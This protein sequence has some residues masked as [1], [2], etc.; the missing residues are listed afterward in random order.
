MAGGRRK[1]SKKGS[2]PYKRKYSRKGKATTLSVGTANAVKALIKSHMNKVVETKIADY[3]F[4]PVPLSCF[5]H[6]V[7]YSFEL[8]PFTLNQ[9]VQDSEFLNPNNRIGDSVF[10][11][12]IMF[13]LLLTN[14][15]NWPNNHIR[16]LLLKCKAG[17]TAIANPT[18]HPQLGN[19]LILP[20]DKED[21]R[22]RDV[23]Y[24]R[25]FS[26]LSTQGSNIADGIDKTMIWKHYV[27]VNK[28][29]KYDDAG[30]G[31]GND[32]YRLYA[33]MYSTQ[34]TFTTTN[35]GRFSYFRRT[36]FQDA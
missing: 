2:M 17:A 36:Y 8:D 34:G 16:I 31:S 35:I 26:T 5:Y 14:F 29:I 15:S 9:G 33:L 21:S 3:V 25:T 22:I 32:V 24:D 7:W 23:V 10:V 13:K 28:K 20:V 1:Y 30:A 11:K 19:N 18:P 27:K 4:E 12:G 6:N